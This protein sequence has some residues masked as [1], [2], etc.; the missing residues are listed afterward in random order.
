MKM[1]LL[2]SREIAS[3]TH[4]ESEQ[5]RER[6]REKR[7]IL[8][9]VVYIAYTNIKCQLTDIGYSFIGL[10]VTIIKVPTRVEHRP[11]FKLFTE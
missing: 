10:L 1:V 4:S 7:E 2:V 6:E 11:F 3:H 9:I 5:A 8:R